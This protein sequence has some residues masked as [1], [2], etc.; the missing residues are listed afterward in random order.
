MARAPLR[1]VMAATEMVP[2]CKVGGLADVLGALPNQLAERGHDVWVFLPFYREVRLKDPPVAFPGRVRVDL[3]DGPRQASLLETR[4]PGGAA[5]VVFVDEPGFYDRDGVYGTPRGEHFDAAARFAFLAR[6]VLEGIRQL[7][8]EPDV[9]H[10][11]DW[12]AGLV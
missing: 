1:I 12:P 6:A 11:H 5:R 7:G 3:P 9:V 10:A 2:Y 8:L 4:A